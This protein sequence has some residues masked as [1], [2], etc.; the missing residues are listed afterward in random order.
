METTGLHAAATK[1]FL[2]VLLRGCQFP[3]AVWK[4]KCKN[5]QTLMEQKM[6]HGNSLPLLGAKN[7]VCFWTF[8][9]TFIPNIT[10]SSF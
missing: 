3:G 7:Y 1:L 4:I 5:A 2:P 6:C 10:F 8:Q 9:L